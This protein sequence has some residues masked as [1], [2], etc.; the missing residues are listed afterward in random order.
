M[1]MEMQQNWWLGFLGFVGLYKLPLIISFLMPPA[2]CGIW[3]AL[4]G[5]CGFCI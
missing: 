3:Q 1:F 2:P 5:S 4:F